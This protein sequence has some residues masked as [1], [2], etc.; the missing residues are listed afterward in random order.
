ME[1]TITAAKKTALAFLR[2]VL[3]SFVIFVVSVCIA[4]AGFLRNLRRPISIVQHTIEV[5]PDS[6][7][8]TYL[9][10]W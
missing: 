3:L 9:P 2:V 8:D 10:R 5:Q 1:T 4:L 6:V 7:V